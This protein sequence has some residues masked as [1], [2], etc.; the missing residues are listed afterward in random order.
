[1]LEQLDQVTHH[2]S[3]FAILEQ[4]LPVP[5]FEN[6][7][8]SIGRVGRVAVAARQRDLLGAGEWE[9]PIVGVER[10]FGERDRAALEPKA[11][12]RKRNANREEQGADA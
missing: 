7:L 9:D 3:W 4:E 2:A 6:E 8:R 11:G 5:A 12:V 10:P 1:M